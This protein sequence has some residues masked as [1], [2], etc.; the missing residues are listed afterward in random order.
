MAWTRLRLWR[1]P[2]S[3]AR[4]F[5]T[6]CP[7]A[8]KPHRRH[9]DRPWQITG[10]PPTRPER[11]EEGRPAL[12]PLDRAQQGLPRARRRK[13]VPL[14]PA[15]APMRAP[16]A[17]CL[18]M[19]Q[20]TPHPGGA[21]GW[22]ERPRVFHNLIPLKCGAP[23]TAWFS[24][25]RSRTPGV[26]CSANTTHP[27]L[28]TTPFTPGHPMAGA[29]ASSWGTPRR[30]QRRRGLASSVPRLSTG[31]CTVD[32]ESCGLWTVCR[33]RPHRHKVIPSA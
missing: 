25:V 9:A 32:V 18:R 17:L 14:R 31:L 1:R 4:R 5:R 6:R 7:A 16:P 33:G 20:T 24:T 30:D 15:S 19:Q 22:Q 10:A 8:P 3:R 27:A 28:T 12:E 21:R 26:L 23:M 29:P 11:R 13:T 2:H